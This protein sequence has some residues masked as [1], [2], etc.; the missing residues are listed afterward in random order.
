MHKNRPMV[1]SAPGTLSLPVGSPAPLI[2]LTSF[3]A[4]NIM[5][6]DI[7]DPEEL[8]RFLSDDRIAWVDVQGL[9]SEEKLVALAEIF[10][11]HPLALEDIVHVPQRPKTET[12][13][14]HQLLFTRMLTGG[15]KGD[16]GMEQIS[17]VIGHNYIVT[18]QEEPGDVLQPV[19]RRL[20]NPESRVRSGGAD[21]LAY[22]LVDTI[23]DAYSP[24]IERLG[25]AIGL[26]EDQVF[27]GNTKGAL[28]DISDIRST[29][30]SVRRSIW[31]LRDA[32]SSLS[33]DDTAA[34][35]PDV[36]VYLRDVYD[37]CVNA[38]DMVETYREL[39]SGLM[40][41]YLSVV[42]H[43]MNEVMKMLTIMST[44]FL[45][46]TF[47]TGLYGMNF[48]WIP[49]LHWKWSYPVLLTIMAS[50]TLGLLYYFRRKGWLGNGDE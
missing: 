23:V 1:G 19:R 29:L 39:A 32:L 17:F 30:L 45:P 38:S 14:Q 22:A 50:T 49:E 16:V 4:Q 13:H 26:L 11:I 10:D 20:E 34:F 33:R 15:E 24:V 41:S 7:D 2:F 46:L 40:N 37:H 44:I 48:Q 8:R 28:E 18:F 6:R 42:S 27:S 21:F 5:E 31:P 25:D 43:R 12:Y 3:N 9:G 35:S 47:F 36:R